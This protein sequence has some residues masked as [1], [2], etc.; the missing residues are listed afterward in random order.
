MCIIKVIISNR[1]TDLVLYS[2]TAGMR[3]IGVLYPVTSL[4]YVLRLTDIERLTHITFK[5]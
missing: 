2:L 5:V 4:R 1:D 3:L